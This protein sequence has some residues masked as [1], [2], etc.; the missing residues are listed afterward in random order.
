MEVKSDSARPAPFFGVSPGSPNSMDPDN[1]VQGKP[2]A[3]RVAKVGLMS[4]KDHLLGVGRKPIGRKWKSWGVLLT[5]S[6]L[7]FS[8]DPAWLNTLSNQTETDN[9]RFSIPQSEVLR[10]DEIISLKNAIAVHDRLYL[11]VTL[12]FYSDFE[13]NYMPPSFSIVLL[14]DSYYLMVDSS[15]SRHPMKMT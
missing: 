5:G 7:L 13:G 2:S 8:R 9:I 6:Q 3:L 10:V 1:D 11:K 4:R 15:F 12:I 14:F